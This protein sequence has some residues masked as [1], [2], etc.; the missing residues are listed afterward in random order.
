[1]VTQ[2]HNYLLPWLVI[3][4]S[5]YRPPVGC[6]QYNTAATGRITTFNFDDADSTHLANQQYSYCIRDNA[7]VLLL[8]KG[9]TCRRNCLP[10]E[11]IKHEIFWSPSVN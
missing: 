10:T 6:L 1:M 9:P 8:N 3:L 4:I 7:I 5:F 2:T 11:H